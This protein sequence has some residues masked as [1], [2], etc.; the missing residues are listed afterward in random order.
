MKESF[1]ELWHNKSRSWIEKKE[2]NNLHTHE[3][4]VKARYSFI[5]LGTEKLITTE[6]I[7]QHAAQ[8]MR[9]PYSQGDYNKSFTYG[10]SLVGEVIN[11]DSALKNKYVHLFAPSSRNSFCKGIRFI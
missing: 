3:V 2:Y 10:Y 6:L 8:K 5:S 1:C 4:R 9:I 11:E 7:P